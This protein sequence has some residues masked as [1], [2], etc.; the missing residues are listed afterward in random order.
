MNDFFLAR[1]F[2]PACKSTN[3]AELLRLSYTGSPIREYL[4]TWYSYKKIDEIYLK[5]C[6][7]I[8]YDCCNCGLVYQGEILNDTTM[9]KLYEEWIDYEK[10][11]VRACSLK[12]KEYYI[13]HAKDFANILSYLDTS[14]RETRVL[15][16]GMGFGTWCYLAKG[17]GC[18]AYGTEL[19]Q[20]RIDYAKGIDVISWNDILS[21]RFDFINAEMVFEHLSEPLEVLAYLQQSLNP[22]GLIKISVPDGWDI[23]KR[24]AAWEWEK[25][26]QYQLSEGSLDEL[27]VIKTIWDWERPQGAGTENSLNAV[28]PLQHINIFHHE[29]LV[30]MAQR[31][32]LETVVLPAVL[33]NVTAPSS[34]GRRIVANL[35]S[36][37]RRYGRAIAMK[38]QTRRKGTRL[39]FRKT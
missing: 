7:Y 8:L 30:Q 6:D 28:A 14:P 3:R 1:K 4:N 15:D 37:A 11:T 2:C 5:G 25:L 35:K 39:F 34:F 36:K 38:G 22:H 33:T 18:H 13:G 29:S 32:G 10:V 17:F 21:Y 31:V 24:L 20:T 27:E 12:T 26:R 23:K 9:R 19:S 16:F